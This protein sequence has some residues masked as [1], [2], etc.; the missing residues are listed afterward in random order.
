MGT[1][2]SFRAPNA[3]RWEAFTSALVS[4]QPR[5]RIRAELFNAGQEW[6]VALGSPAVAAFAA[7]LAAARE[8]LPERVARAVRPEHAIQ[9]FVAEARAA[10]AEA[11]GTPALAVAER[12][13]GA[14]LTRSAGQGE[15]LTALDSQ[16]AAGHLATALASISGSVGAYLGEVLGQYARHVVA[17]EVGRLTE[18]ENPRGAAAS[19]RTMRAIAA[20]AEEVARYVSSPPSDAAGVREQWSSLVADAFREGR[21]LPAHD[22]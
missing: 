12:A 7:A 3:P 11:G 20:D 8:D 13:L 15:S 19:R 21:R 1:S 6:E 10:S 17:R 2:T 22:L 16:T 9:E 5:E 14:L 4:E 18:G